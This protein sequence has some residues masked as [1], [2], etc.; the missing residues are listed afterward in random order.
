[1]KR[2][3][4]YAA[5]KNMLNKRFFLS[6]KVEVGQHGYSVSIFPHLNHFILSA[7]I[8]LLQKLVF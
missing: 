4:I 5:N 2:T 7:T 1:M 3:R 6:G 8:I